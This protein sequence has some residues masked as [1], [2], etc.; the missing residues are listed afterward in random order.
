MA[1][2]HRKMAIANGFNAAAIPYSGSFQGFEEYEEIV[3]LIGLEL[4]L[5]HAGMS[6]HDPFRECFLER[7]NG[8]ALMQVTK[9]RSNPKRARAHLIDRMASCAIKQRQVSTLLD[10]GGFHTP[11]E[12]QGEDQ[13]QSKTQG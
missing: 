2:E 3:D 12:P 8:I 7:F 13:D 9:W 11:R 4:E 10:A 6:S 1:S 5:R